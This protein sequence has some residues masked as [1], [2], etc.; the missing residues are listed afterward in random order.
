[1]KKKLFEIMFFLFVENLG[2]IASKM[3]IKE[4]AKT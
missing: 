1:M 4:I 2:F 3:S